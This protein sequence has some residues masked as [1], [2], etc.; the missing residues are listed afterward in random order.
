MSIEKQ[1]LSNFLDI[2]LKEEIYHH[3][4]EE[5]SFKSK[6]ASL[7]VVNDHTGIV[8]TSF[9]HLHLREAE[10]HVYAIT[11]ALDIEAR[12]ILEL[13]VPCSNI[14]HYFDFN[15]MATPMSAVEIHLIYTELKCIPE[16]GR[17]SERTT[18]LRE[19]TFSNFRE[20]DLKYHINAGDITRPAIITFVFDKIEVKDRD[21]KEKY[22]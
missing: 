2:Q 15:N 7:Q 8:L 18:E 11:G 3:P 16:E 4:G 9:Q 22:E 14:L 17:F 21:E 20:V 5:S 1:D 10:R 12:Y 6:S 19:L 13:K